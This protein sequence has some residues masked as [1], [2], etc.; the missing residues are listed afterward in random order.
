MTNTS[1]DEAL[2]Q[3]GTCPHCGHKECYTVFK[4]GGTYC[5]SCGDSRGAKPLDESSIEE[6]AYEEIRG[7]APDVCKFYEIT[8]G[9]DSKGEPIRHTYKYPHKNKYRWL[10]KDFSRNKGFTNDHLFGMDKFNASSGKVITLVEGELDAASAYQMLGRKWPVVS[11]PCGSIS[12]PLLKNVYS[13]LNSYEK[14]VIAS[15]NDAT[16]NAD[17]IKLANTFPGKVYR[18]QLTKHK[19]ANAFLQAGDQRD[20]MWAWVNREKYVPSDIYT[21]KQQFHKILDDE[22]TN[23]FLPT[24][25]TEFNTLCKGLMQGHLTVITGP[26]GQGK[27]EVL[28]MLEADIL[29]NHPD[30]PIAILHMEESKKTC[31]LSL[32]SYKL[33]KNLRDP[34][35]TVP[36]EEVQEA[37]D[38]LAEGGNMYL[39]ELGIDEDPLSIL[40]KVRFLTEVYGCKYIF[41]DPIQQLSYGKDTD[42]SEEQM[43]TKISVQLERLAT[44]FNV[45]IVLTTHV[46]DDG[47]TRSSR[48]IGKSASVRIDLKR[49]H[50]NPDPDIRN[51]TNLSVSKNRPV[52]P[53]GY[54]GT[55]LFDQDTFILKEDF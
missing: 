10:P 25:I 52:G 24:P 51:R 53:T 28:R 55:L 3:H 19:D 41:I 23:V 31:L 17:A 33:E 54:G 6:E 21:T 45:G 27:T 15:E 42:S 32:A 2:T 29:M 13:F 39:F 9:L 8:V 20:F 16:A 48:M 44:E 37:I 49:D 43:L 14:I 4:S 11:L 18:V 22:E 1:G 40:E 34:E 38:S 12:K 5:H 46:N 30:I 7:I 26:E 36:K 47:Q 50:M 35:N